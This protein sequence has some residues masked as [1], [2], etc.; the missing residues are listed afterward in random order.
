MRSPIRLLRAL[1]LMSLLLLAPGR[2]ARSLA[3]RRLL[4][5]PPSRKPPRPR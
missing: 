4:L 5:P 1:S 2:A 3:G